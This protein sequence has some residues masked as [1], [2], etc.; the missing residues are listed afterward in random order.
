MRFCA[1]NNMVP[2][3]IKTHPVELRRLC[4]VYH[5]EALRSGRDIRATRWRPRPERSSPSP[6]LLYVRR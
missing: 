6:E 3:I 4:E 5:D 1:R 2:W